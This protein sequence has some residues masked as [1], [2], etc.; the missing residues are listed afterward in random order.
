MAM[1][2]SFVCFLS[3]SGFERTMNSRKKSPAKGTRFT[4][5][6]SIKS[7]GD[8]FSKPR[9]PSIE[10]PP[11]KQCGI[12]QFRDAS[13]TKRSGDRLRVR[14]A[15]VASSMPPAANAN[16]MCKIFGKG[17]LVLV[18]WVI[19]T[20][21]GTIRFAKEPQTRAASLRKRP[22]RCA[23][24]RAHATWDRTSSSSRVPASI[25]SRT[26]TSPSR[27][28]S[29]WSSR[30]SRARASRRLRSTRCTPRVSA[31]TSRAS[32]ATR[33]CS[34]G[35]MAKP[36]LD[37]IDGLSPGGVHR[38][39]DH[40]QEPAL[41]GG[42]HHRDLRL[43]APAV[44]ARG[45]A[46]LPRVRA[47]HQEADHRPGDRRDPVAGARRE[48]HRHGAGGGGPQGRV[49]EAVRRPAEG[50]LLARAHRRR[51]REAGRRAAHARTRR[52]STSSTWWWT[53]CS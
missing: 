29:S 2:N 1:V 48:G 25:T 40:V 11:R 28:T 45:R 22:A 46:A 39:E 33:A 42:H 17:T 14:H 49:H 43:P 53:A 12:G 26:S 35:Q 30:A 31:A 37:S 36:D 7:T 27:A 38:P 19:A 47:R 34:S 16:I 5:S 50:G 24:E 6:A 44:R 9:A 3:N 4:E 51:D 8:P 32:P 52:S 10:Y 23:R 13:R 20:C 18:L 15:P 41:H 21:C